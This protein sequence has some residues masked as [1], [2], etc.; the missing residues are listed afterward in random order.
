MDYSRQNV[1]CP[2]CKS[3]YLVVRR[4]KIS[5]IRVCDECV[6]INKKAYDTKRRLL[7][8]SLINK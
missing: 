8:R 5:K 7:K 4:N 3:Y 2:Q 1:K 6:H